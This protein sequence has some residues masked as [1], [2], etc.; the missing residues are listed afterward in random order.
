MKRIPVPVKIKQ[1]SIPLSLLS[2]STFNA[3]QFIVW[4]ASSLAAGKSGV[5]FKKRL[6]SSVSIR[7]VLISI[8]YPAYLYGSNTSKERY[9]MI[10]E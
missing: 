9:G 3:E 4:N 5:F 2:S 1:T 7:I 8:G 6:E 10:T